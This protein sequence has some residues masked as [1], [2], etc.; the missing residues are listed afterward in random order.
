M[1][2]LFNAITTA[3][4]YPTKFKVATPDFITSPKGRVNFQDWAIKEMR[5]FS[6]T[7]SGKVWVVFSD[8]EDNKAYTRPDINSS[9]QSTL[10][11]RD[12]LYVA[13]I[14]NGFA[15]VF[16]SSTKQDNYPNIVSPSWKGWVPI[17]NL[18][19]W[20]Q[21]PKNDKQIYNKGI[22]VY[23][24]SQGS[25]IKRNPN[26][27]FSP[28]SGASE[29]SVFSSDLDILY[30]MKK[31]KQNGKTYFLLSTKNILNPN[32]RYEDDL[33]GWLSND[34]LTEWNY[35]LLLEPTSASS[36]V[37]HYKNKNIFPAIFPED[38]NGINNA[39]NYQRNGVASHPLWVWDKFSDTR[40]D[41]DLMRNP[42]LEN[43]AELYNVATLSTF[44]QVEVDIDKLNNAKRDFQKYK[45]A[46]DNI[47]LIFVID[48][49]ASMRNY[50]PAVAR[51]LEEIMTKDIKS[52]LKVGAVLYKDYKDSK[53]VN[54][55]QLTFNVN[56]I[57]GFINTNKDNC[58]SIDPDDYEAM[59]KGLETALDA[60]KMGYSS[61]QSNFIVLIG[62]AGN[63]R[64]DPQGVSWEKNVEKL[65]TLMSNNN[66]NFLAYQVN[67]SGGKAD[68][69]FGL[70][71]GVLQE[72]YAKK[73]SAKINAKTD[74]G[75]KSNRFYTLE[76]V[77]NNRSL[78]P[79]YDTYCYLQ[80]GQSETSS[81]LKS[82]IL[83]NFN[84]F[85]N[86][87]DNNIGNLSAILNGSSGKSASGLQKNAAREVLNL[88]GLSS[89]EI[90]KIISTIESGGV[91]KFFGY[92]PSKIKDA[93]CNLFD[94]VLLFSE[95]ELSELMHNL[96]KV[97]SV[98]TND[99]Q[100]LQ[101]ALIAIGQ[102]MIGNFKPNG[103]VSDMLD[104]IYG[105]P[106]KINTC[107]NFTFDDII[108]LK[109][110]ALEKYIN[111]F[112][113]NLTNL[114]AVKRNKTCSFQQGDLTFYWIRLADMPGI[115]E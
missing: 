106:V 70:Q 31:T 12:K 50:Y 32:G 4:S 40:M 57:I 47:N 80:A 49:T 76:R 74:F 81:G 9:Q 84:D 78:L 46:L 88:M 59:F 69:D 65:A 105:L 34:Y 95:N 21:C 36:A 7:K 109:K 27:L 63:H 79:I 89:A 45:D 114:K 60:T 53:T 61:N 100:A 28:N 30:I 75:L 98:A 103:S 48:N 90:N 39:K 11:F 38:Q 44:D 108:H 20:N 85:V 22:V 71:I 35:R 62:D 54:Y 51:S 72:E 29:S 6:S 97:N 94:F 24:P 73:I 92:A 17:E 10:R 101:D 99:A 91:V 56:E 68:R 42:I 77:D 115:C 93:P 102:S 66:I 8:R 1:C 86:V 58:N 67:N 5:N 82:I 87:V 107:G 113:T 14:Q 112:N 18:L 15:L 110:D 83:D 96:D 25:T 41:C 13:D 33:L 16:S 52:K 64:K 111:D 104:Q 26:Y 23:S 43:S 19:M 55:K 3:Q 2:F 37:S